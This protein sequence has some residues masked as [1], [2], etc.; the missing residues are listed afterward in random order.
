MIDL[1]ERLDKLPDKPGVYIMKNELDE[2]I[3]VGKAK[4]LRKRVRQYFGSY[5]KSSKKVASMVSKIHDFEYIIVEN[6]VESLVLESNLIKDNLPKYNILLRDDKQYPYIKV[7]LNERFPR[8]IK[9]RRILKD[10]AKY[11]GPYPDVF[12]VNGSIETFERIYPLRTCNLNLENV[13]EKS[14]RP[15]LNYYIGKCLGPCIGNVKDEDYNIMVDEVLSFLSSSNNK[16]LDKLHEKMM[17]YSRN[18]DY[19][20]AADI[21]DRIK[22]LEY[23]KERQLISDPEARDDKDII[24]L[25]KGIEE[26][27]IQIFFFRKGKIIGREH[28][29]IRDYYNDSYDEIFSSFLKQ[30]Y[31]GASYIPKEIIIEDK[32]MDAKVLEDWLSEKRGNKVT[33]TVPI[34]GD[35]KELIKMVKRNALD[36]IEKYGDKYKKRAESNKL[37]LEEIK[38]LIGLSDTPRRIEAYDISNISGVESVGSMVVFEDGDSKKSDYRKFRIKNV[39]GPDD[40]SSLKEVIERRFTRGVEEKKRDKNTSFSN[41]PDLIMMDGGKGQVNAAKE[42]LDKLNL[43]LEICGLVKD[44]FHRTRG[45]IYNNEEYNVDLNSRA[46]KMIYKIQEEAHRFAINYHRNLR[47]K[48]MFKSE[49]DDIKMIGPKRKENLLKHFK[50]IDK[51]KN[52]SVEELLEVESMNEKSANS[53]Y[54]HF[55]RTKNGS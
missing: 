19:E 31:I 48:T 26:V 45:I 10:G 23:L 36:M 41:F 3:Y 9:T 20:N 7:M 22:N 2:I 27:L 28:Y 25:A 30:F 12:A 38:N 11:F 1:R 8:V 4:S 55:R 35:K 21:R 34:K 14:Y 37:A 15:C 49:L 6:E 13:E 51:I 44:D 46:Y 24:A 17:D 5:G 50:S 18:L 33:I 42:I 52:A 54:E 29:M 39:I 40:Y 43:K 47:S 16:L 53:L 32:P